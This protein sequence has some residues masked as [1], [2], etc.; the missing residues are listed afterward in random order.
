[1][2]D[3]ELGLEGAAVDVVADGDAQVHLGGSSSMVLGSA[4]LIDGTK[5]LG[6]VGQ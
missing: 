1:M 5:L 3:G 2:V 6:F 4:G